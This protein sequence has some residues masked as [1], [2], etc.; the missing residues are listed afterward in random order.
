[1]RDDP[2]MRGHLLMLLYVALLTALFYGAAVLLIGGSEQHQSGTRADPPSA[3][4][5]R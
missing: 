5:S 3:L 1:M 2:S 4:V